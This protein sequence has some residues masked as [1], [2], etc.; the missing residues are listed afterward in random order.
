MGVNN[1]TLSSRGTKSILSLALKAA[2]SRA[3]V[4][5]PC[6]FFIVSLSKPSAL[7]ELFF[8]M[9]AYCFGNH[10]F[11][12]HKNQLVKYPRYLLINIELTH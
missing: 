3:R 4:L 6:R 9:L 12:F 1:Y 7:P 2:A 5:Q 8:N 10:Y 11:S